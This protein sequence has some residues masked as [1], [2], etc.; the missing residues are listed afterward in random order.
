V[1]KKFD[2][3]YGLL[4]S[5]IDFR[6]FANELTP[7]DNTYFA[8]LNDTRLAFLNHSVLYYIATADH[9]FTVSHKNFENLMKNLL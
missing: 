1:G 9:R 7:G 8:E 5:S 3:K 2:M 4:S 6:M